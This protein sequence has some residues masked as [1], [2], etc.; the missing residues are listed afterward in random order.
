MA[1]GMTIPRIDA[2]MNEDNELALVTDDP[3]LAGLTAV[4]Y[5]RDGSLSGQMAD[6]SSRSLGRLARPLIARLTGIAQ[7]LLVIDAPPA[8]LQEKLLP[9]NRQG[10]AEQQNRRP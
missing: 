7:A 8:P 3:A 1:S 4:R 6:G 9:L 10:H 2:L 5:G